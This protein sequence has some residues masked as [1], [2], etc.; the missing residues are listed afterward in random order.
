MM[1][2][3]TDLFMANRV[4]SKT[5]FLKK[6]YDKNVDYRNMRGGVYLVT[7]RL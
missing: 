6:N 5:L 7:V 3:S 4:L 2:F 1:L